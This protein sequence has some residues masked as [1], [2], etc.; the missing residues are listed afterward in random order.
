MSTSIERSFRERGDC[1]CHHEPFM[2]HYYLEVRRE[3]Y[4][5]FTPEQGRPRRLGDIA[6][7]LGAPAEP[8]QPTHTFF[9]DMSYYVEDRLDDLAP[10]MADMAAVFLIRDP[11]FSLASYARLDP[12]FSLA[13]AG[14]ESQWR[15]LEWLR[16]RGVPAMVVESEEVCNDPARAIRA[17]CDF[18]GVPFMED[19]L[20]W[21]RS[22]VPDDWIQ[23][24][25]WH[26][27]SM[28]STG[29]SPP[30]DR[31]PDTV[32]EKAVATSPHLRDYLDHHWPFYESLKALAWRPGGNGATGTSGG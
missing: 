11:R 16:A 19:A 27:S 7:M 13:E 5:D 29:F 22:T 15:H 3:L 14:L 23:A 10:L 4:P 26:R 20:T 30:D 28:E 1:R 25:G 17:I 6:E 21:D 24:R 32:F 8:G 9:K 31:D 2:Y 12:S 18:S